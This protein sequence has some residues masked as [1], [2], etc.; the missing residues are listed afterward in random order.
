MHQP[1]LGFCSKVLPK[2]G[3]A[4]RSSQLSLNLALKLKQL[5]LAFALKCCLS[6]AGRSTQL[7]LHLT[8]TLKHTYL[9]EPWFTHAKIFEAFL[10]PWCVDWNFVGFN[11]SASSVL[12]FMLFGGDK[13]WLKCSLLFVEKVNFL[14]YL[15]HD[16]SPST[17]LK[18]FMRSY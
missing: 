4:T 12:L 15:F 5:V 14:V 13:G 11:L 8:L 1:C 7:S 17:S 16:K 9:L 10:V 3:K 2:R 6:E 18:Y